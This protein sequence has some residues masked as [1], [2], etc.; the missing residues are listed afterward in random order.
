M[1]DPAPQAETTA[2]LLDSHD[3]EKSASL[4]VEPNCL[5]HSRW[6]LESNLAT[7][8]STIP[9]L[10]ELPG[11]TLPDQTLPPTKKLPSEH[12]PTDLTNSCPGPPNW[13]TTVATP[14]LL[15]AINAASNLYG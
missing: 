6:K 14:S 1:I 7:N 2:E 15:M 12:I 4:L 9:I 5:I 8:R 10:T 3:T 13:D 11:S